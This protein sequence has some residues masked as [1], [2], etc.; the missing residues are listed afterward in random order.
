[1]SSLSQWFGRSEP[2]PPVR[3]DQVMRLLNLQLA[4]RDAGDRELD[5]HTNCPTPDFDRASA[6]YWA[7]VGQSTRAELIAADEAMRRS[8]LTDWSSLLDQRSDEGR[9]R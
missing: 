7:A 1:M 3:H 6:A 8:D 5:P 9:A 2:E 4:E